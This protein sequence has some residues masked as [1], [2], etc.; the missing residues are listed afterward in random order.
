MP[1]RI[2]SIHFAPVY[3]ERLI[4]GGRWS[5]DPVALNAEPKMIPVRDHVQRDEGPFSLGDGKR[6]AQLRYA[7][8]AEHIARDIVGEWTAWGRGMTPDCRPGIWIIRDGFPLIEKDGAGVDQIVYDVHQ[9]QVFEPASPDL[10]AQMFEEDLA[11][12]RT[13]DR[14]YAEW[15]FSQGNG[16]AGDPR[17]IPFIPKNY[18]AAARH[19]GFDAIWIKEG[20]EKV[21]PCKWCTTVIPT[22]AIVCPKC[23]NIINI[24]AYAHFE[25]QKAYA[26][27]SA[28]KAI[29]EAGRKKEST[30]A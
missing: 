9:R 15:C 1:V 10:A 16:I 6:R 28:A 23:T 29:E 27:R 25:A 3:A 30:A 5:I 8:Y 21:A 20:G 17:L 7:V 14:R 26:L 2:A 24:E 12:A 19:Y 13:A 4:Y 18:I 11:A 22:S